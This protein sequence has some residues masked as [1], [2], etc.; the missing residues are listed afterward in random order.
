MD[1]AIEFIR[2]NTNVEFVMT[3]ELARK[4]VWDYPL[5]ALREAVVNAAC[6][7]DYAFPS[8]IEIRIYDNELIVWSPGGLP[9]GIRLEDLYGPHSSVPRNR[10]I[11][12]ILHDVGWIEQWGSGIDKMRK[13]CADAGLP[14]PVFEEGQGFSVIFRKDAFTEEHLLALGLKDRQ[15][16]AVMYAKEMGKIT[17][18]EY[19]ELTHV[20]KPMATIDLRELVEKTILEKIGTTGRGAGYALKGRTPKRA[21]DGLKKG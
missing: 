15:V 7:R 8:N 14:E 10:E 18:K 11:A 1:E 16:R 2:K 17:N 5:E 6:H 4:E 12:G 9:P 20:S 13:A 3:G 19:R 21:N